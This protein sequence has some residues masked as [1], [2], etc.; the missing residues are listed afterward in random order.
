V[1]QKLGA[2]QVQRSSR[3]DNLLEM[4]DIEIGEVG[5]EQKVVSFDGGTQG[6]WACI[7]QP[8]DKL[9]KV[10]GALKEESLFAQP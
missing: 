5:N 6:Q 10:T 8:K 2:L 7:P 4:R 1:P 9:R 3:Y